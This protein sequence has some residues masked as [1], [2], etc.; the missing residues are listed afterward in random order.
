MN[1]TREG[2]SR[3]RRYHEGIEDN[4]WFILPIWKRKSQ[5]YPK[6]PQISIR[7]C[8]IT[9]QQM[10][11]FKSQN[12]TGDVWRAFVCGFAIS[13]GFIALIYLKIYFN[14]TNFKTN[15]KSAYIILHRV[16]F[17]AFKERK[18]LS[19]TKLYLRQ[20]SCRW[21]M[22]QKHAWIKKHVYLW[23]QS[24]YLFGS[25]SVETVVHN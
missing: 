13:A 23:P 20:S 9:F 10:A 4:A 18:P 6:R 21:P 8:G 3:I 25:L 16:P 24:A 11:N 12:F 2:P 5:V 1:L 19:V 22:R 14:M 15:K 7:K 17:Y